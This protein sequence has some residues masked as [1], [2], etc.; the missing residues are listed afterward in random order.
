M[1]VR[2]II[3]AACSFALAGALALGLAGCNSEKI[4]ATVGKT[5]ITENEIT[6]YIANFRESQGLTEDGMW[7]LYLNMHISHTRLKMTDLALQ[8]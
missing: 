7:A 4:A 1:K 5:Q 6:D 8:L 3:A 2:R